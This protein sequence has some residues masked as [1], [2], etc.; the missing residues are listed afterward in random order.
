MTILPTQ[1]TRVIYLVTSGALILLV[2]IRTN[3]ILHTLI[4][5]IRNLSTRP[6]LQNLVLH[7]TVNLLRLV[8][9]L[10]NIQEKM[11]ICCYLEPVN[12]LKLVII[13]VKIRLPKVSMVSGIK[14]FNSFTV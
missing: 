6:A 14:I 7:Q 1:S 10:L 2:K 8:F 5:V 13:V 9:K 11:A 12:T 4:Q 3:G